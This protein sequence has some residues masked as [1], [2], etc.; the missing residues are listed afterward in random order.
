MEGNSAPKIDL[1][2]RNANQ[3]ISRRDFLKGAAVL[4][5][6][7]VTLAACGP[8]NDIHASKSEEQNFEEN[9][10]DLNT[11]YSIREQELG[12]FSYDKYING[13]P[14]FEGYIQHIDKTAQSAEKETGVRADIFKTLISSIITTHIDNIEKVDTSRSLDRQK[15]GPMQFY[16]SEVG[17]IIKKRYGNKSEYT[18]EQL[19]DPYF[20]MMMGTIYII[21]SL[22]E[23]ENDGQNKD[24]MQLILAKY[25][26]S[27]PALINLVKQN[28][29]IKG[30]EYSN[31]NFVLYQKNIQI[32]Q[33]SSEDK[34]ENSEQKEKGIDTVWNNAVEYWPHTKIKENREIFYEQVEKYFNDENNNN[35]K[36]NRKELLSIF[37]SV[38]M[39]ESNG[40]LKKESPVSGAIGWYQLIPRW[41]HL[42]DFNSIHGTQYTYEDLHDNDKV[43]IEVGTW[44]LMR[45]R[46]SMDIHQSM[47][48]FKG[49][50]TFG[51]NPDD[52]IWWNR[53][54]YC[55]QNLLKE[56]ALNMGYMDYYYGGVSFS[57]NEFQQNRSHIANVY[58]DKD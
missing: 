57:G 53:V 50:N 29:N 42:E 2:D 37:L 43:S 39:V 17:K 48:F 46:N 21:N 14:K 54:S 45:Y 25:Y 13:N 3:D 24:M 16:P 1:V 44:T 23:I 22:A 31:P 34:K 8:N 4:A 40:G 51:Y 56:D 49:G 12:P 38:A 33:S 58:I 32:L 36:L 10:K 55:T 41:K 26:D 5:G 6:A 30:F 18:L 11:Q 28:K 52:G 7:A 35:P 20:N 27:S 15:V 19:Q 47:K 9:I